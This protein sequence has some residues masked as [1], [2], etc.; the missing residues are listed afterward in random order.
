MRRFC[1]KIEKFC[2]ELGRLFR[3]SLMKMPAYQLRFNAKTANVGTILIEFT[4]CVPVIIV[5]LFFVCDHFRF[6]ELKSKVKTSAYLAASM[7]QQYGNVKTNKKLTTANLMKIHYASFM[8][9]FIR[10]TMWSPYQ[11]GV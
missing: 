9:F 8:N 3:L 10:Q 2:R 11:F 4:F 6:Y 5:L 7:A 1:K